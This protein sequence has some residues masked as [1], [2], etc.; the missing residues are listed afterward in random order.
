MRPVGA[1]HL[2]DG[3]AGEAHKLVGFVV[4]E[5]VQ[6]ADVANRHDHSVTRVIR[7]LVED[8]DIEFG[9]ID[10]QVLNRVFCL[11]DAVAEDTALFFFAEH[12]L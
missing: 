8:Y 9:P 11:L 2:L 1:F 5:F 6:F 10:Y 7:V 12:E 4:G 3:Q